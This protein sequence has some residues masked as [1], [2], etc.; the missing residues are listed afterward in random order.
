MARD[1]TTSSL[2]ERL[3]H[4][5]HEMDWKPA[6]LGRELG[7][8]YDS[9]VGN[10]MSRNSGMDARYAFILQDK[11]RW[12]ARW[13]LYGEGPE[14]IPDPAKAKILEDLSALPID[15]LRAIQAAIA[16]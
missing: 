10:W 7:T 2:R 12:N 5:M 8:A 6:D 9:T 3:E 1:W 14:R 16:P 11:H 13:L 4:V 15:K